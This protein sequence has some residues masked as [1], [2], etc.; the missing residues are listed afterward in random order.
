LAEI[1]TFCAAHA[2]DAALAEFIGPLGVAAKAWSELTLELGKRAMANPDEMGAAAYDYLFYS[3]YIAYAY[4]WAR[5][6]VA[7]DASSQPSAFREA[8]RHTARF[9][10]ARILPRI[11]AHAAAMRSGAANLVDMP[12]EQFG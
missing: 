11:H 9:Y 8:K 1:G 12:D 2:N 10:F 7:A 3:G 6:V 5:S 4:L